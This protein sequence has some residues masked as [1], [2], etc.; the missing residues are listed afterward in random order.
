MGLWLSFGLSSRKAAKKTGQ[1]PGGCPVSLPNTALKRSLLTAGG[2]R[3]TFVSI[4]IG[5]Q[6]SGWPLPPGLVGLVLERRISDR[7]PH[8][9]RGGGRLSTGLSTGL[10]TA[11]V[12]KPGTAVQSQMF[13]IAERSVAPQTEVQGPS[14]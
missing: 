2:R 8:H 14:D 1:L 13:W 12:E 4:G 10:S 7:N 6:K 5:A 11:P 9:Y 3:F